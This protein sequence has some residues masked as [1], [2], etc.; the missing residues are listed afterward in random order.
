MADLSFLLRSHRQ[1]AGLTQKQLAERINFSHSVISRVERSHSGYLPSDD[2][3]SIFCQE[4]GLDEA[5]KSVLNQTV[6]SARR[7]PE[8]E[9]VPR[10][11]GFSFSWKWLAAGTLALILGLAAL[12]GFFFPPKPISASSAHYAE[13]PVGGVL[14]AS[15]FENRDL[16]D[17]K[18]LNNGR[19]EI[20]EIDG[21]RALGVRDQDPEA[22]PNAYLLSSDDWADYALSVEVVFTSGSYEQIYLVV[23]SAR[24]PNCSGYR[25]GGNRLGVSIFRFDDTP[26][27]CDGEVL[28]ENIHFPLLSG[29]HYAMQVEV[30]GDEIRYYIDS[31]LILSAID[32]KYPQ[33]GLGF[34]SYQVK[35]AYFDNL[36]IIKI[37]E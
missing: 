28:A 3:I 22:V 27:S 35:D 16:S 6:Q 32:T 12:Y 33:G 20:F 21:N 24:Q 5:E 30:V 11:V 19:W 13:I 17:W 36:Q 18:N 29:Q 23:R 2:F 14:Y 1:K 31:E 8:L 7:K 34:L 4:L 37:G 15:D 26:D 25:I 9:A 10:P